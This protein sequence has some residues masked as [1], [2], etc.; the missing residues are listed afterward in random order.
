[1]RSRI[2]VA[3]V[4]ALAVSGW[5]CRALAYDHLDGPGVQADPS[6]DITGVFT[7]MPDANHVAL[8]MNV[9]PSATATAK[10]ST[11]AK[12]VFHTNGYPAYAAA[13]DPEV[14]AICTFDSATAQNVS[15]WI[16][17]EYLHG[18][19]SSTGGL[20]TADGK[21]KVFAGLRDDPF[22]FNRDG[23]VN[24]RA[25]Y[26]TAAA[27]LTFDPAGCPNLGAPAS[28]TLISQLDHGNANAA[29][30]DNFLSANVLSIVLQVDKSLL[31]SGGHT[32]LGVWG[33][34]NQ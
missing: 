27:S 4:A 20:A 30:A 25:T 18:D 16:G 33:S 24:M 3:A 6:T 8:V 10:F 2:A 7:W 1:V 14:D 5:V 9:F 22:F 31:L 15:C 29:P 11:T 13:A 21:V 12:Y 23:F 34:T 19:A 28:A 17:A 32:L 26:E